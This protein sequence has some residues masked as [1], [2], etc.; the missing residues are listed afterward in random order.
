VTTKVIIAVGDQ[1]LAQQVQSLLLEMEDVDVSYLATSHDELTDAVLRDVAD[2]VLVHE[3]LGPH[4][5][6]PLMRDLTLRRPA[7]A[8]LLVAKEPDAEL[9][10]AAMEAGARGLVTLPLTF[11]QVQARIAAAAEYAGR[12]R[13]AM[14]AG[15]GHAGEDG[16]GGGRARVVAF[17][18]AKGGVGV[19][20][21]TSHLALDLARTLPG[22]EICLVDLDLE[23]GDVPGILEV[24][25]RIGIGDLAKVADDLS[26]VAVADSV[27]RHESGVDLLLAPPDIRDVEVVT[28]RALRLVMSAL[29]QEYDVLLVDL[30]SHVTPAQATVVELADEIVLVVTPDVAAV[31]GIRRTINAWES[32]GVTKESEVRILVNRTSRQTT[33]SMETVRQLTKANVLATGVPAAFRRLEPALNARDPMQV[34]QSTWWATLRQVGREIGMVP[35]RYRAAARRYAP[36][37]AAVGARP[38]SGQPEPPAAPAAASRRPA[39]GRK[40]PTPTGAPEPASAAPSVSAS[41]GGA[42]P[43][44]RAPARGSLRRSRRGD[45][46][47]LTLESLALLPLFG[48]VAAVV[49]HVAIFG[50]GTALQANAS[51]A[52]ARAAGIG[53]DPQQA[54]EQSLPSFLADDVT[55][56]STGGGVTVTLD[57]SDAV[58][59]PGLPTELT[60][61]RSVV[62]EP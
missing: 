28:P 12:I 15:P 18:G 41:P 58:G 3:E 52:A 10:S 17:A 48:L 37:E 8:V 36:P 61:S 51:A 6:L 21:L 34:G 54:A 40:A 45:R 14:S 42:A 60:T 4:P 53:D 62:S 35:S 1:G 25:H 57:I 29:R 47:A 56:R 16:A 2:V 38:P 55:A 20:T 32:L 7:T 27:S 49:W 11:E 22:V 46:G 50:A 24:R 26:P 19:T 33:V 59:F 13:R 9:V 5:V 31:R 39:R 23:K 44:G 30:G 43:P